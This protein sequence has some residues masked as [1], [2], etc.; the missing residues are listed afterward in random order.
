M[1]DH[2]EMRGRVDNARWESMDLGQVGCWV[3]LHCGLE[4]E[5]HGTDEK[6]RNESE[7]SNDYE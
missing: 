6:K 1:I 3:L 4:D 5:G 7:G 2:C